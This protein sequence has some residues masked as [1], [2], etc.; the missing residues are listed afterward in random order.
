M[1]VKRLG[2]FVTGAR[3][4]LDNDA[5]RLFTSG[6]RCVMDGYDYADIGCWEKA[7]EIYSSHLPLHRARPLLGEM[8][9]FVRVFRACFPEGVSVMPAMCSRLSYDESLVLGLVV[10]AQTNDRRTLDRAAHH[11]G[12]EIGGHLPDSSFDELVAASIDIADA[13]YRQS[14]YFV[15]L[16]QDVLDAMTGKSNSPC[17]GCPATARIDLAVS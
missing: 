7:W 14:L 16:G 9:Y 5:E 13:F 1:N 4:L 6:F 8:Q 10:S 11:L 15:P 2:A 3:Q 17:D 12:R